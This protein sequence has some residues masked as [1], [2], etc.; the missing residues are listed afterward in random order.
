MSSRSA[1]TLRIVAGDRL[2]KYRL[3]RTREPTGSAESMYSRINAIR[4]SRCRAS[5][6]LLLA[7][8][9]AQV[10]EPEADQKRPDARRPQCEVSAG[11]RR[12]PNGEMAEIFEPLKRRLGRTTSPPTATQMAVFH[13]PTGAPRRGR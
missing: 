3:T 6:A 13:R 4:T 12:E 9:H 5:I 2:L 8:A 1:I 10:K 7:T 11:I